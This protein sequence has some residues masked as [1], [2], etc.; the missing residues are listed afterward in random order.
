MSDDTGTRPATP[1]PLRI[2]LVVGTR[3]GARCGVADYTARLGE[4]MAQAGADVRIVDGDAWS[5]VAVAG[6]LSGPLAPN[7]A[8][9]VHLQYPSIGFGA[10]L[11]PHALGLLARG[12]CLVTLH[13]YHLTR[14]LRRAT[15]G[16]FTA[17]FRHL[18]FTNEAERA[19]YARAFPA[20]R[21][22][23]SVIPL[24]SNLPVVREPPA[25]RPL[26]AF[27]GQ[28]K[29]RRGLEPFIEAAALAAAAGRGYR[30][31]VIGAPLAGMEGYLAELR[32]HAQGLS[33]D[34]HLDLDAAAAAPILARSWCAYLPFPDG[35]SGRRGT[36]VAALSNGVPVVTTRGPATPPGLE[37]AVRIAATPA[38]ALAAIDGL[39]ADPAARS[40]LAAAGRRFAEPFLW[41]RIAD[42][43]LGLY[44]ALLDATPAGALRAVQTVR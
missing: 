38:E 32:R 3:P 26:I 34:W 4:A 5:P 39:F 7:A 35:A 44:R 19:A 37:A 25:E 21:G 2:A 1:W 36:L 23:S 8:D 17:G 41:P 40:A 29:P 6:H 43:H 27:F 31:A 42:R 30:F 24:G 13:E 15:M 16:A 9:L 11:M 20:S 28:I 10:S 18:V 33:L 12:R 22:R 14:R